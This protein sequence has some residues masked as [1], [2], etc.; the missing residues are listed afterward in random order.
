MGFLSNLFNRK[1]DEPVQDSRREV[2]QS[3]NQYWK[4]IGPS[5]S[6]GII[7]DKQEEIQSENGTTTKVIEAKIFDAP[8]NQTINFSY[9]DK[10]AFEVSGEVTEAI[11]DAVINQ[12]MRERSPERNTYYV[13][14]AYNLDGYIQLGSG[15]QT[16]Q[17]MFEN[18]IMLERQEMEARAQMSARIRQENER[19][20]NK[21]AN[22]QA[23]QYQSGKRA[24]FQKRKEN[25]FM[26]T[27]T[28]PGSDGR[29]AIT[30]Y[31]GVNINTGEILRIRHL[32]R[33]QQTSNGMILYVANIQNTDNEY[34]AEYFDERD[35]SSCKVCFELPDRL[36]VILNQRGP[37]GIRRILELLSD[38]RNFENQGKMSYIG[39]IDGRGVIHREERASSVEMQNFVDSLINKYSENHPPKRIPDDDGR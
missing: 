37:E 21:R 26:K 24:E 5:S 14:R 32:Q 22:D 31:D 3:V 28:K 15:S 35:D 33:G 6:I 27:I 1:K 34:D 7:I 30:G 17:R 23:L 9:A 4:R 19:Q 13:G 25:P 39:G 11:L 36:S 38:P 29:I 18:D 2:R 20:A 10:I 16:A 12:Y 8:D